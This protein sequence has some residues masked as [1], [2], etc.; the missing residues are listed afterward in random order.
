MLIKFLFWWKKPKRG[1]KT[2]PWDQK[3]HLSKR[4]LKTEITQNLVMTSFIREMA[5]SSRKKDCSVQSLPLFF[6]QSETRSFSTEKECAFF[7]VK[8]CIFLTALF[9]R[10]CC[11]EI[12]PLLMRVLVGQRDESGAWETSG[13]PALP[14][15]TA[16]PGKAEMI[17]RLNIAVKKTSTSPACISSQLQECVNAFLFWRSLC[18]SGCLSSGVLWEAATGERRVWC[19]QI[20]AFNCQVLMGQECCSCKMWKQNNSVLQKD[21]AED[22]SAST[23]SA[24]P[25]SP[26]IPHEKVG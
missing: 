26:R 13:F 24:N 7:C 18:H 4:R 1:E 19:E 12:N 21:L 9:Q 8:S 3:H 10:C 2:L 5:S 11:R 22:D 16:V 15:S 14:H 25:S 23:R 17:Q 20:P 6:F